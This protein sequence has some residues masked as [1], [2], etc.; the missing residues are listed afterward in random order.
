MSNAS[1]LYARPVRQLFIFVLA[2]LVTVQAALSLYAWTLSERRLLPELGRKA[3]TTGVALSAQLVRAVGYGIPLRRLEGVPEYFGEVL[4]KNSDLAYLRITDPGGAVLFG[5]SSNGGYAAGGQPDQF[6]DTELPLVHEGRVI[7]RLHVG[8]DKGYVAARVRELRY[9]I[10]IVLITSL[11]IAFEI[12]WFIV[13]L[14]FTA[15]MRQIVGLMTHIAEGDFR[16]R[17]PPPATAVIATRLHRISARL[18]QAYADLLEKA[19]ALAVAAPHHAARAEPLLQRLRQAYAFGRSPGDELIQHRIVLVRVLSFLFMFAEMLSRPFLPVYAASLPAEGVA[20]GLHASLPVTAFL[21]GVALSMPFAG[22]WSD[23]LG[24][25][26]SYIAGALTVM[27]G[28][29]ATGLVP[30][31]LA[32]VAARAVT[33][34]GYAIMFMA[35]Q[36]YVF[37]HTDSGNRG[38]GMALFVGAI[39][40]A[41][42]CAPAVGGILADRIGYR[43]VFLLGAAV[44]LAAAVLAAGVLQKAPP[45]APAGARSD[46]R[47]DARAAA[48]GQPLLA[49]LARNRRFLALSILS[50]VPAKFL[51]SGFLIFLVPVLL[52]SLGHSKSEIGRYTMLYGLSSLALAPLF[53]HLADRYNAYAKLVAAGG[54]LTGMG[55]LPVAYGASGEMVMLGI[56]ALGVGQ[57]MSISAQ[58]VLVA[59]VTQAEA[60]QAGTGPI[61]GIFRLLERLGAAAGPVVTGM[62]AARYGAPHA[63]TLLGVFALGASLLF[64]L[65]FVLASRGAARHPGAGGVRTAS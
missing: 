18:N 37:D 23:R 16:E 19:A 3:H 46:A 62:L 38:K 36:G 7:A 51:Y 57:S 33:G 52:S 15:P 39:M 11:L 1:R 53:A 44:A 50:G 27:T 60:R 2:L 59:R 29:A 30:D 55:L 22:S 61:V 31:Y 34:V 43:L 24:R 65:V 48:Q 49:R 12:L 56:A 47:S 4:R 9:D 25:R 35:C 40:V 14:N 17:T 45:A 8:V 13:T 32:L 64:A 6:L 42:I 58:L 28:L 20:G 26:S 5:S 21:L 63:M 10:G 54:V 41:E